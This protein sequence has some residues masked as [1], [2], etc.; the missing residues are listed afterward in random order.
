MQTRDSL[1]LVGRFYVLAFGISWLGYL[2]VLLGQWGFAGFHSRYWIST[3]A[4]MAVGPAVAA[5]VAS[6]LRIGTILSVRST[7]KW[8]TCATLAPA[9]LI[10]LSNELSRRLMPASA[11]PGQMRGLALAGLFGM[12][13]L[14]NLCEEIGWRGFALQ[15]LLRVWPGW[16]AGGV[17]GLLWG[18]WHL[19]LFLYR[20]FP[21]GMSGIPWRPWGV[22]ILAQSYLMLWL[23]RRTGGSV[24]GVTA[25]HV[26]SNVWGA[27]FGVRSFAMLALVKWVVVGVLW[28]VDVAVKPR[29]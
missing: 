11:A 24:W 17:V 20:G 29:G 19:P 15:R 7:W 9:L 23:W 8:L 6:D 2:P 5:W 16:L 21:V 27:A 22:G 10:M 25:F 28:G 13:L 12:M 18:A 3:T 26:G 14:P 4:L 1:R